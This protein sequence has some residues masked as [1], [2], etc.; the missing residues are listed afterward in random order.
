MC[1]DYN[2]MGGEA[3]VSASSPFCLSCLPRRAL[4]ALPAPLLSALL[5]LPPLSPHELQQRQRQRRQRQRQQQRRQ[6]QYASQPALQEKQHEHEREQQQ[7]AATSQ[8]LLFLK[9]CVV[10]QTLQNIPGR[11]ASARPARS[12][13]PAESPPR[14]AVSRRMSDRGTR[15]RW[16]VFGDGKQRR[17]HERSR[18]S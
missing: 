5:F 11:R 9:P 4:H 6:Q 10:S 8:T 17:E 14:C 16:R 3:T 7:S 13:C 2:L 1:T 15:G 18:E 12:K